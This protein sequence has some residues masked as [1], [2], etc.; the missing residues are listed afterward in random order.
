VTNIGTSIGNAIG[1]GITA[2]IGLAVMKTTSDMLN[3]KRKKKKANN[4]FGIRY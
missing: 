3:P 2:G 1:L 4:M